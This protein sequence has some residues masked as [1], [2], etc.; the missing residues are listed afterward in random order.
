MNTH[1]I[2]NRIAVLVA[3]AALAFA[4][5]ATLSATKAS[6][7]RSQESIFQADLQLIGA[8]YYPV[9]PDQQAQTLDT[10]KGLGVN[11][12]RVAVIWRDFVPSSGSTHRPRGLSRTSSSSS[13]YDAASFG[14]LDSLLRLARSRHIGVILT[15]SAPGPAWASRCRGSIDSRQRCRPSPTEWRYFMTALGRRYSGHFAGLPRVSRWA[16]WNEPNISIFLQPQQVRSHG[17]TV[18]YAAYWYRNLFNA[19]TDALRRTGHGR[20]QVMIGEVAPIG[21]VGGSLSRRPTAS[22]EFLRSVFCIDSRGHR[23]GGRTAA[24]LHCGHFR[25]MRPTAISVHP[26]AR[27]GSVSPRFRAR[28]DEITMRSLGLVSSIVRGAVRS[29]RI[30][31]HSLPLYLTEL[32]WQTNPPDHHLGVSLGRQ[33]TYID[34]AD[35]MA[36]RTGSVRGVSQYQLFDDAD[37]GQGFQSGLLFANGRAK[38]SFRTYPLGIWVPRAGRSHVHVFGHA[39]AGRHQRVY[40]QFYAFFGNRRHR[41]HTVASRRTNGR[42]FLYTTMRARSGRWRLMWNH[43]GPG[44]TY[45]RSTVATAR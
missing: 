14:R 35:Y 7:N 27:G 4:G 9:G 42:G 5:L 15:P 1:R 44:V 40:I 26:Y 29:H 31:R 19:S 33:A 32:G 11:T 43:P 2:H 38:P 10:L 28:R 22:A 37:V 20:D 30:Y 6:A 24:A 25:R 13:L 21:H 41:W 34:E 23:L 17:R 18:S 45:S 12:V 3:L 36:Y 16:I 8:P 39:R